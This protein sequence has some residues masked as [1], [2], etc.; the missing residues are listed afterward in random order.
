[1]NHHVGYRFS[2][3]LGC[4]VTS[5]FLLEVEGCVWMDAI[6]ISFQSAHSLGKKSSHVATSVVINWPNVKLKF[7]FHLKDW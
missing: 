5:L 2:T 4:M 3:G 6:I 7:Q 1:M